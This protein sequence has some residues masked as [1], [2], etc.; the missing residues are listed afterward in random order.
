[1]GITL[2]IFYM[3]KN[4]KLYYKTIQIILQTVFIYFINNFCYSFWMFSKI[5]SEQKYFN[6]WKKTQ[7]LIL[8]LEA[9]NDGTKYY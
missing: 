7:V 9:F 2:F 4:I 3:Q 8:L 5:C 6:H 1:M